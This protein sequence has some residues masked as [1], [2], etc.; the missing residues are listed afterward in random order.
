MARSD[1]EPEARTYWS[2]MRQ[3]NLLVRAQMAFPDDA[4]D[5]AE[6]IEVLAYLTDN[7]RLRRL[8]LTA[9]AVIIPTASL[10]DDLDF[11]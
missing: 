8:C 9:A 5:T 10:A 11:L 2:L 6:E 1:T 4:R 7:L 3:F